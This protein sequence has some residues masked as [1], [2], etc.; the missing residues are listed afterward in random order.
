M[1]SVGSAGS[2]GVAVGL[3][4]GVAVTL[5]TAVGDKVGEGGGWAV[6]LGVAVGVCVGVCV[7][8]EVGVAVKV[9]V[10]DG[11]AAAI[12]TPPLVVT[13]ATSRAWRSLKLGG[14]SWLKLTGAKRVAA[15]TGGQIAVKEM[16]T[17]ASDAGMA[18]SGRLWSI[19]MT[20]SSPSLSWA[21]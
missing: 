10:G 18:D 7:G 5:G 8:V 21:S 20:S 16:V 1:S 4:E 2:V 3:G 15:A 6:L 14:G 19:R 9:G 12:Q 17:K 11:V 13:P